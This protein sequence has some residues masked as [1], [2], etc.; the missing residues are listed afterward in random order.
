V[1]RVIVRS[2][3]LPNLKPD[4]CPSGPYCAFEAN[5]PA[6]VGWPSA[7]GARRTGTDA[8]GTPG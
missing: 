7:F 5:I 4:N 3:P 2:M 1:L 8:I 6:R